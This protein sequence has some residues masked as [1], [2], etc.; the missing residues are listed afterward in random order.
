MHTKHFTG[1]Y[2]WCAVEPNLSG[3]RHRVYAVRSHAHDDTLNM[4]ERGYFQLLSSLR[5]PDDHFSSGKLDWKMPLCRILSQRLV[6]YN[7]EE[8]EK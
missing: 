8:K 7:K 5:V 1:H 2:D 6:A 4:E 3:L